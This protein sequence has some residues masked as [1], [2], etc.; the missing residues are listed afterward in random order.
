M[1]R[2]RVALLEQ[3][4]SPQSDSGFIRNGGHQAVFGTDG[5][6]GGYGRRIIEALIAGEDSPE[7]LSWKVRGR[8]RK[9]EKLVRESLKGYFSEFHR[10][11]LKAYYKH[12][13]FLTTEIAWLEFQV[14]EQMK[15]HAELVTLLATIPGVDRIVA[16]TM[17]AELGT[18][19]TVFPDGDHCAGRGWCQG[20]TRVRESSG[21]D[22]AGKETGR[23]VTS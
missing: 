22:D 8:L 14:E 7:L 5:P 13:Q 23:C 19:P 10:T 9:K 18:D 12:Y 11:M 21:A 3:Q 6:D 16:W 17:I 1:L 4:P 20:R 15:P 2:H